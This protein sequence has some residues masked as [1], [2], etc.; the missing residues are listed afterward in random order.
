MRTIELRPEHVRRLAVS[1]QHL[2]GPCPPPGDNSRMWEVLRTLRCLQIDPIDVVARSHLLVL[3]S[4]LGIYDQQ[5]LDDLLWKERRLFEYWAHAASI[6]LAEDFPL[7]QSMMRGYLVDERSASLRKVAD[8]FRS[9]TALRDSVLERL[10]AAGPQRTDDFDDHA[11][12]AWQSSGWSSGRNVDRMLDILW[13]QGTIMVAG[14]SGKRRLWDLSERC[15]PSWVDRTPLPETDI[16]TRAAEHSLRA[17]G[18]GRKRDI[19]QYFVRSRYPGLADVIARLVDE[20]RFVPVTLEDA[21][22]RERWYVHADRLPLVDRILGGDWTPRTTL[23]SPFD[24]LICQRERTNRVW[25]FD[26]RSE[27]YVPKAKRRYGYYV[28]PILHGDALIGRVAPRLDRTSGTLTL[29]GVFA[30]PT[31]P[32]GR[33]TAEAVGR[34]VTDL[35][36]FLGARRIAPEGPIP[37]AWRETLLPVLAAHG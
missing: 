36:A 12:V 22:A 2:E 20:G 15:L 23:L 14:R 24:N 10:R 5:E 28:L 1:C 35:A 30:E 17:L 3:R 27:I 9:N 33:D 13:T 21:P 29:E 4:R 11:G 32:T 25:D 19:E 18:A 26:F 8:W 31:A 37:A 6:V 34:A 16:V 7:H